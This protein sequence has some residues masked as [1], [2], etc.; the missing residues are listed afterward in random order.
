MSTRRAYT[1]RSTEMMDE[2]MET[3]M[4][5]WEIDRTSVIKLALYRLCTFMEDAEVRKMDRF[6]LVAALEAE[7]PADFP[8]F[9]VF[10]DH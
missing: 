2:Y 10:G 9:G 8:P 6:E 1:F 3:I 4:Q 5:N 7:K